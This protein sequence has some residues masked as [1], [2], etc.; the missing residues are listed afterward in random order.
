MRMPP[1]MRQSNASPLTLAAW[2]YALLMRW[3][4]EQQLRPAAPTLAA[5]AVLRPPDPNAPLQPL[6]QEATA[7]RAE[8]L[9]GL[10][11]G[12]QR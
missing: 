10:D 4:D 11:R 7:R 5:A 1:F 12:S 9:A 3:V 6:T 8:V 2:Q